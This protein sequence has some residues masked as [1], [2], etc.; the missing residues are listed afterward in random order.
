ME[1]LNM[2][3]YELP[4]PVHGKLSDVASWYE[5]VENSMAQLEH[6]STRIGNLSLMEKY[7]TEAWKTYNTVISQSAGTALKEAASL[8]KLVQEINWQRKSDQVNA[9]EKLRN[10]E[11]NWVGLVSKNYEIE[12]ACVELESEI[13]QLQ[14]RFKPIIVQETTVEA[15]EQAETMLQPQES[16]QE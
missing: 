9:G 7:G 2:K 8:K 4:N 5:A 6:Q 10:L 12:Q 11:A 3:R 15:N 13:T 16:M 1:Q 14:K